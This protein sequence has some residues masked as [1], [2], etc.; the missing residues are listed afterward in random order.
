MRA[1]PRQAKRARERTGTRRTQ[2]K[3]R[4]TR[5]RSKNGKGKKRPSKKGK[6]TRRTSK[7][8]NGKRRP[9]KNGKGT[10]RKT[11]GKGKG[12]KKSDNSNF[13]PRQAAC[14]VE[15]LCQQ[16]KNY[17]KF[18]NQLRKLKRI[19]RT[20]ST[21][22]KKR[23]KSSGG[24]FDAAAASN[25]GSGNDTVDAIAAEL[26]NCTAS[27]KENCEITAIEGCTNTT[28]S[29]KC[30]TELETWIA[31]WTACLKAGPDCCACIT[32]I[33]P[34][35]AADCLEFEAKDIASKAKKKLCTGSGTKGSFGYCRTLQQTAAEEGP[36]A[37]KEN[38]KGTTS[39]SMTTAAPA[40]RMV[41][42]NILNKKWIKS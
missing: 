28:L 13:G 1:R 12:S 32:G 33:T 7:K 27:A 2:K 36:K 30:K 4:G 11:G 37:H 24:E 39:A 9:S 40:R 16:I 5:Q 20:C 31:A 3:G 14:D 38:C 34:E 21:M 35:P 6:G 41:L 42:R 17:I 10:R 25:A 29:D 15:G 23:D 22:E 8:G 19:T 18:S 26:A